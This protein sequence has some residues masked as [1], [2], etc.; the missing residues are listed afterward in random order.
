MQEPRVF[1]DR[2]AAGRELAKAVEARRLRGPHL[3]LGLP[4]G[5][6]PVAFEVARAL[7]A[8]LDVLVVRKIGAPGQPEL[9]IGAIASGDVT[10]RQPQFAGRFGGSELPF[11]ELAERERSELAR[12]ELAY[13][14]DDRPA[15]AEGATVILVDDGLATGATML[16]A[17]RAARK[18]RA[19]A[20]VVAAP[21]ASSQA[22]AAVRAEADDV[23]I[24]ETPA[25]LFAI[26]QW[27][28]RFEQLDDGEVRALLE[29]A[30]RERAVGV[31]APRFGQADRARFEAR[32]RARSAE[33]RSEIRDTLLRTDAEQYG[34]LAGEVH[35]VAD[36]AVADLLVD[37]NLAEITRDVEELRDVEA[38]LDRIHAGAFGNCLRC[39][40]PIDLERLEAYPT[41]KRC[42][43]CQL[44]HERTRAA[45]AAA[46][47]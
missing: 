6:V 15:L 20:V 33:L 10:V 27:Y 17:V 35:D 22:A 29:R 30:R 41:A 11:E 43:A 12:R 3:V 42:L 19:A 26:G 44:E 9:A 1:T 45:P 25:N 32:L 39:N 40:E 4:R 47:L 34:R 28:F 23:V 7:R 38:A 2:S 24:L 14:G 21:V 31:V 16:A 46:T 36:Q 13:R 37:V 5:G 8:P 18:M